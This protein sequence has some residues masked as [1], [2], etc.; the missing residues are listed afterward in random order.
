MLHTRLFALHGD[1]AVLRGGEKTTAI[2]RKGAVVVGDYATES[3]LVTTADLPSGIA[4]KVGDAL[5]VRPDPALDVWTYYVI[6]EQV[7]DD[8]GSA[9]FIVRAQ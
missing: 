8:G 5:A 2:I 1:E 9:Q 7:S 3:R 4:A 6:D